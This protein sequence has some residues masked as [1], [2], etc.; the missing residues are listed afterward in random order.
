MTAPAGERLPAGFADLE[1]FVAEWALETEEARAGKRVSTPI[2]KL[3]AFHAATFPR[4][5]AVIV[6]LNT[7]PNDPEA[8]APPD[9][10]LFAL[11]QMVMASAPMDLQWDTSDIEDVFPMERMRFLPLP[12]R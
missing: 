6:Y 9:K 4:M 7:L 12:G 11:A 2:A 3:R 1:P 5:E 8:L 10:C